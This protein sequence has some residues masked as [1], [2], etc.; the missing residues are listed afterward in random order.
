MRNLF[1]SALSA[2]MFLAF[3][4]AATSV[5]L[6]PGDRPY[7]NEEWLDLADGQTVY[8]FL[9]GQFYGREYYFPNSRFARFQHVSGACLDGTW[10][11]READQAF[12]FYWPTN[13]SCFLH[14]LR[15]EDIIVLPTEP[16][17]DG[18]YTMQ[19]VG[20]IVP[21]GFDCQSGATS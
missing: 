16:D 15:G 12:C 19:T 21:G 17:E 18:E 14:V 8:Y 20:T 1:L 11:Y 13:T 9:N 5:P 6:E 7:T 4:S 2:A 10:E 3:P